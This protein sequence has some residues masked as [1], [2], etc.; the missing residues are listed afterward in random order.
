MKRKKRDCRPET[1]NI[2]ASI[3][4]SKQKY[5]EYFWILLN[6][7]D[8]SSMCF[9]FDKEPIDIEYLVLILNNSK[10]SIMNFL[11][12]AI[13]LEYIAGVSKNRKRIYFANPYIFRFRDKRMNRAVQL[14]FTKKELDYEKPRNRNKKKL[15]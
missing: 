2:R 7:L 1:L 11:R 3:K 13:E 5:V 10:F 9:K 6:M 4:F 8:K 15:Y 12:E 14:F